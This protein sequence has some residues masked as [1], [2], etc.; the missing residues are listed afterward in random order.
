LRQAS[1]LTKA[2]DIFVFLGEELLNIL[3]SRLIN[4]LW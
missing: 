3:F 1:A 2:L 4:I